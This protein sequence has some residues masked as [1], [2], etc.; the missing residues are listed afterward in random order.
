MRRS[1]SNPTG[2]YRSL[3][4]LVASV[5]LMLLYHG[6][7]SA[8]PAKKIVLI[9]G[10]ASV[11]AAI[12]EHDFSDG[13]RLLKQ[14]LDASPDTRGVKVVAYPDGWPTGAALEGASTLVFYF[15]GLESHPLN[16]AAHR[17]QFIRLLHEGAGVIALHQAST[18]GARH[19]YRSG[20]LV[21]WG[22]LW[23]G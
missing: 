15:A 4:L 2:I 18:A 22:A 1:S 20:A 8:E 13:I 21:G 23:N 14:F 12:G 7:W 10:P 16:D 19:S 11:G 17:A 9:G 3:M 5:F 6:V